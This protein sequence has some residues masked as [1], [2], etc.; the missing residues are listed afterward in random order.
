MVGSCWAFSAIEAVEGVNKIVT[1]DLISLSE[2][3]L[4]DCDT[5][6]NEGCNG[7]LMD[8][9]FN[10]QNYYQKNAVA[11]AVSCPP[12]NALDLSQF[13]SEQKVYFHH[14]LFFNI[15]NDGVDREEDYP[16][17][18]VDGR[19]D[20][21][22]KNVKFVTIDLYEDVPANSEESLK[23]HFLTNQSASP[24]RLVVDIFDGIC[25]T[26]LDHG[27]LAVGYGTENGKDYWIVKN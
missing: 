24:L 14:F 6:Y 8:Y 19:C 23:M 27:V 12:S 5:P 18:D 15:N 25:G 1:G 22:R 2:Q 7:G 9:A 11:N 17:K 20:Q 4:V 26:N 16:Y 10:S 3:E 13:S 21:T